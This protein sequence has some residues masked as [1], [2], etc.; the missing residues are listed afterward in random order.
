MTWEQEI[1]DQ[2]Y[3]AKK[4]GLQQGLQQ[5]AIEAARNLL[6]KSNLSPEVIADC[7]SIPLDE[8]RA[9]ALELEKETVQP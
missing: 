5:K 3:W 1:A 6:A 9:I 4:E 2:R 7:C 8:V